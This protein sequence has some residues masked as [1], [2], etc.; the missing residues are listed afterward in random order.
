MDYAFYDL[1]METIY[2]KCH[3]IN[4]RSK[5]SLTSVGLK[6]YAEDDTFYYFKKTASM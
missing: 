1:N 2:A 5:K 4:E 6:Q 3:K